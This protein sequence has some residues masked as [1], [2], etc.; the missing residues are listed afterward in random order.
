MK[1]LFVFNK[2]SDFLEDLSDHRTN[3]ISEGQ[4]SRL[5]RRMNFKGSSII[6]TLTCLRKETETKKEEIKSIYFENKS[7]IPSVKKKYSQFYQEFRIKTQIYIANLEENRTHPNRNCQLVVDEQIT[8]TETDY[9]ED[10]DDNNV[11]LMMDNDDRSKKS[12][13]VKPVAVEIQQA[14]SVENIEME[15]SFDSNNWLEKQLLLTNN[16]FDEKKDNH[17]LTMQNTIMIKSTPVKVNFGIPD[18]QSTPE[19]LN[20]FIPDAKSTPKNL[21]FF[22]PETI[23]PLVSDLQTVEDR[24]KKK[25][26]S[27]SL[28]GNNQSLFESKI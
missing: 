1:K 28:F 23:D 8:S 14:P 9:L 27:F 11:D 6:Y 17:H 3:N 5:A 2:F 12:E 21:T 16:Y 26:E 7:I 4:F 19:K 15:T 24:G 10:D 25:K 20:F 18:A 13:G 22:I